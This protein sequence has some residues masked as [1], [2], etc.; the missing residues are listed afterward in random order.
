MSSERTPHLGYDKHAA[1]GRGNGTARNGT[2]RIK[3]QGDCGAVERRFNGFDSKILSMDARGMTTRDIQA[4]LEGI[5][6]VEV[7]L[8]LIS[9]VTEAVVEEVTP[10]RTGR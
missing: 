8:A 2:S 1:E 6:G 5:D 10:G 9:Q 7:N 4:H 3:I